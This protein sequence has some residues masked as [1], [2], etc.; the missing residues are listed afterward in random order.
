MKNNRDNPVSAAKTAIAFA[1]YLLLVFVLASFT[2]TIVVRL[3]SGTE[4]WW[5]RLLEDQG[6]ARFTRRFMVLWALILFFPLIKYAGWQG[7]KDAGLR[8]DNPSLKPTRMVALGLMIGVLSLGLLSVVHL[9]AG[10]REFDEVTIGEVLG[11]IAGYGASAL[12]IGCIEEIFCRGILF[13]VFSRCWGAIAAALVTS[14]FFAVAHFIEPAVTSF[15]QPSIL[16]G[17]VDVLKSMFIQMP[18]HHF[19]YL[20][21]LN[22]TLLGC[23]LCVLT[24]KTGTVWLSIGTHAGWVW[25]MKL[26]GF[27]TDTVH[28]PEDVTIWMGQR[29]DMM[30]S[31]LGTCA[32]LLVIAWGLRTHI[33]DRRSV[34]CNVKCPKTELGNHA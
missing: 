26:N 10:T 20:R 32:V 3:I 23:A 25:M 11:R 22:L 9:L 21:L 6:P 33:T 17:T 13:R 18:E 4:G 7:W 19:F 12:L 24:A 27:L 8:H 14:L 1:L 31:L 29:S 15:Q 2:A 34:D 30:D 28:P 16:A 5:F